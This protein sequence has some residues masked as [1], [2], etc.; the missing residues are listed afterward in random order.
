MASWFRASAA[1]AGMQGLLVMHA[2]TEPA[3]ARNPEFS[4]PPPNWTSLGARH[5]G[6]V[7]YG[8]FPTI[9]LVYITANP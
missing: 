7:F 5:W 3:R 9:V 8:I 1:P 6:K 2:A 4:S